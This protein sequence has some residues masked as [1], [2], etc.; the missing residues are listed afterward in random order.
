MTTPVPSDSDRLR[1]AVECIALEVG[2]IRDSLRDLITLLEAATGIS[3]Y[4]YPF[5]EGEPS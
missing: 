5:T 4:G 2:D 3:R 1:D